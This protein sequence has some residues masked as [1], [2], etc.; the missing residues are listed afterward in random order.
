M[1]QKPKQ[2]REVAANASKI[3]KEIAEQKETHQTRQKKLTHRK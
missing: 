3:R 2:G 1:K